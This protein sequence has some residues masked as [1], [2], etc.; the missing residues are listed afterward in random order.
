MLIRKTI[1]A[2]AI[3][4]AT[5]YSVAATV[6][7]TNTGLTTS[8][9]YG[10]GLTVNGSF[11]G[12][13][14]AVE[15]EGAHIN[16][17][18]LNSAAIN[19]NGG[20]TPN[21]DGYLNYPAG[22][23]VDR[24]DSSDEPTQITGSFI[25]GGEITVNGVEATAILLDSAVIQGDLVN[26][27]NISATDS[28]T[29]TGTEDDLYG[30][31]GIDFGNV[32]LGGDLRNTARIEAI[33]DDSTALDIYQSSVKGGI[34]NQSNGVIF[35]KGRNA[36][37]IS[38]EDTV[39]GGSIVNDGMIRVVG[40]SAA[41]IEEPL[42][43][44][45]DQANGIDF[46][47]GGKL[48]RLINT[49]T[50][51]AAGFNANGVF[52]D[53]S[54]FGYGIVNT[55][56][57]NSEGTGIRVENFKID[58]NTIDGDYELGTGQGNGFL[59]IEQ[60]AGVIRGQSAAIVGN[61]YTDLIWNGGA[62]DG[63]VRGL[64]EVKVTGKNGQADFYGSVIEVNEEVTIQ[65]GAQLNLHSPHTVIEQSSSARVWNWPEHGGDL[66][67]ETGGTLGLALSK[68]TNASRP[69][70]LVEGRAV[71]EQGSTV[72]LNANLQDFTPAG[73][74]YKLIQADRLVDHGLIVKSSSALLSVSNV[75]ITSTSL[76]ADVGSAPSGGTTDPV[77]DGT[78][79]PGNGGTVDPAD[80][81]TVVIAPNDEETNAGIISQGGGNQG[82]QVAGARF[83]SVMSRLSNNDPIVSALINAGNDKSAI[84]RVAAQLAPQV[85]GAST[86]AAMGG[87]NLVAGA[88]GGRMSS[89]RS[90]MA[91]GDG[92][93]EVGGWIQV[94]RGDATQ[95][96]R[97]GIEGYSSDSKGILFGADGKLDDKTTLGLSYSFVNT[98]VVSDGAGRAKT[99]IDTHALSAYGSWTENGYFV[100][101][102]LTYGV[103]K[104]E[105]KR[106]IATTRATADYDSTL[107]GLNVLGG[108]AFNLDN[109]LIIEPRLA[110]R[111]NKVEV[112]TYREKGSSGA[113]NVLNE[114]RIEVAE[115]GAGFRV[116][117][118]Y[119]VA[120]GIFE[121]EAKLMAFHD[122]IG[123]EAVTQAA[124]VVG[125]D[126]FATRGAAAARDTL[127]LGLGAS[128]RRD[129]TTFSVGYD[130]LSKS[131]YSADTMTAKIRYD[132]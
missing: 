102:S 85:N 89:G 121:P 132:F 27:G 70:L 83:V 20:Y 33:G 24:S 64:S 21:I 10:N 107:L 23:D 31:K 17:D 26:N 38:L 49:G 50:I 71:F 120:N 114:Q 119:A 104:N 34:I 51:E 113:L 109:G 46:D 57:I 53:G 36:D 129:Q 94:L 61:E 99:D 32:A 90:G 115:L 123:D 72:Q 76:G 63:K 84:A 108:Y 3:A 86:Q 88:V 7:L 1:L 43:D 48:D 73:Q 8:D 37:G 87:Q 105:S 58:P 41:E 4:A 29:R 131:D 128:Y 78:T 110:G 2:A 39:L 91:S 122:F 28:R 92:F 125:G 93:D 9:T 30:A 103:N 130:R 45:D 18:F 47:R 97:D 100:D 112:D 25:N 42:S 69:I 55:G 75:S 81:G 62:I 95:D 44:Y 124:F 96:L 79:N 14:D 59:K 77:D 16:G 116:G 6:Q 74:T 60:N 101:A 117:G 106:T 19:I 11:T 118:Q 67:V 13:D 126:S 111:Y 80:E 68:E 82:A 127:E 22:I 35:A 12:S 5:Q 98:D 66:V 65:T 52:V 54:T 40:L 56:I 15:L